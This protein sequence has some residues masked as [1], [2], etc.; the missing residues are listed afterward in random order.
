MNHP[1]LLAAVLASLF[2]LPSSAQET[3]PSAPPPTLSQHDRDF[4]M[5]SLHATRKLFLDSVAGLTPEQWTF[6]AAPDRW[7]IAECAE[8]IA[9][10]EDFISNLARVQAMKTPVA[11]EKREQ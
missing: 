7:S 5:S 1:L 6:K 2:C 11:P 10:A 9:L 3:A 4:A 8:H